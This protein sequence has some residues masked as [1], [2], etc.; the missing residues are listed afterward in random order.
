MVETRIAGAGVLYYR[1]KKPEFILLIMQEDAVIMQI[2]KARQ[3]ET[4]RGY[5]PFTSKFFRDKLIVRI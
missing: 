5:S 3:R 2:R 4:V 1:L